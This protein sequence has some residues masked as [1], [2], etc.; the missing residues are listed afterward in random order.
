[1]GGPPSSAQSPPEP[2]S[3]SPNTM[4]A[5]NQPTTNTL[6]RFVVP[7]NNSC[8]FTSVH[9]LMYGGE[10]NLDCADSMRQL[11]AAAVRDD[12]VTY[13]EVLLGKS[14]K[15]YC[16]WILDSTSW[17]GAIEVSILSQHFEVEIDVVDTQTVRMDRFGE[18]QS[19]TNRIFLIYDGI[20]YDPLKKPNQAVFPRSDDVVMA[21]ALDLASEANEKHQFTDV[22]NFTLRC[23]ICQKGLTGQGEAQDHAKET[24]HINFGEAKKSK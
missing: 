23:L 12:P 21:Q 16:D 24:G 20:H 5:D 15:E 14:N 22:Q 9:L 19:Y 4:H 8:L 7:A 2:P 17:G 3:Q 13:N 6:S 11:V 1:M 10:L 18:D